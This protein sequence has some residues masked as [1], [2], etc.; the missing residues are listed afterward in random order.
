VTSVC[1]EDDS[2]DYKL[3]VK[4]ALD[5]IPQDKADMLLTGEGLV[6]EEDLKV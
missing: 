1:H 3:G 2:F 5:Q 6:I 4:F